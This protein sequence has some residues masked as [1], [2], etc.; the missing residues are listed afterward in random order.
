MTTRL[1]ILF[2]FSVLLNLIIIGSVIGFA[3]HWRWGD[4]DHFAPR[5]MR[6]HIFEHIIEDIPESAQR[7]ALYQ[8]F[9]ALRSRNAAQ[10]E[11]IRT[12]RANMRNLADTEPFDAAAYQASIERI[13]EAKRETEYSYALLLGKVM[14]AL[15]LDERDDVLKWLYRGGGKKKR[16][17]KKH[18]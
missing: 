8:E 2:G 3:A 5:A 17:N 15:P 6:S 1:K 12:S 7:E 4:R 11:I 16:R 18:D 9:L 10:A 14:I 13:L